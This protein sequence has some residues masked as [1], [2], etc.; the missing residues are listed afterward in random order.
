MRTIL[1]SN[2][3]LSR[4]CDINVGRAESGKQRL[5]LQ[6]CSSVKVRTPKWTKGSTQQERSLTKSSA[7]SSLGSPWQR[8]QADLH[9]KSLRE[10]RASVK[11]WQLAS[12]RRNDWVSNKSIYVS[13]LSVMRRLHQKPE[14][15]HR[16]QDFC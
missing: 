5:K 12:E 7:L 15:P 16:D 14:G 10:V 13:I 6:D 4:K 2:L 8:C 1:I 3:E 9:L 11:Y